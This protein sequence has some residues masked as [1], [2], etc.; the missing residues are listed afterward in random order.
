MLKCLTSQ[1]KFSGHTVLLL[2]VSGSMGATVS[3][4]SEITRMDAACGV[5]ML[6]REVC[7]DITI[8]T[9]SDRCKNVPSRHGFALRDAIVQSQPHGST[10]TRNAIDRVNIE[11]KYDRFIVITDEQ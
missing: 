1:E 3:G 10:M 8:Y 5:A 2:D 7:E 9:F 11:Q 4:K 6:M